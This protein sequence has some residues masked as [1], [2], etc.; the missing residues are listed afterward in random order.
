MVKARWAACCLGFLLAACGGKQ[1]NGVDDRAEAGP[2]SNG[3]GAAG[4]VGPVVGGSA[5]GADAASVPTPKPYI[6]LT[7]LAAGD[8]KLLA[9][10]NNA[11]ATVTPSGSVKNEEDA[12]G[13]VYASDD[14]NVWH[15]VLT[16]PLVRFTSAAAGNGH[17]A[18]LGVRQGPSA[19][20]T[21]VYVSDDT[22]AWKEVAPPSPM[23]GALV[24]G[25]GTFL[26]T[27]LEYDGHLYASSDAETWQQTSEIG[28]QILSFGAGRF[29][30]ARGGGIA[31]STDGYEWTSVRSGLQPID[32]LE[33][34]GDSFVARTY[35]DCCKGDRGYTYALATSHDGLTWTSQALDGSATFPVW[36]GGAGCIGVAASTWQLSVA[37]GASCAAP[38]Y[39]AGADGTLVL[40][41]RVLAI[42]SAS[43]GLGTS[44]VSTSDGLNWTTVLE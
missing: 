3:S 18:V 14:G 17:Y 4:E 13:V 32:L 25:N 44:L 39:L 12:T 23:V 21:V 40:S 10:A 35:Y 16:E 9:I 42:R 38:D 41:D 15:A 29:V 19:E 1:A 22:R 37:S 24:F 2:M 43:D 5:A 6:G 11:T 7:R 27:D 30:A 28:F 26:A 20:E 8:G 36:K 34:V 33:F 31:V